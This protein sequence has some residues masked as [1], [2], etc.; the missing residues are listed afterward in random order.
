MRMRVGCLLAILIFGSGISA[1]TE[2]PRQQCRAPLPA[3][4]SAPNIFSAQQERDLG[5][6]VAESFEG[7][8]TIVDDEALKA[9]LQKI[10]DRLTAHLPPIDLKV[11]VDLVDSPEAN[12]FAL[13]GGRVYI[14]RKL[15]G[16]TRREDELAAVIGHELG[17][18][19]TRQQSVATTR[20]LREVLGVTSLSD[21]QDVFAKYN[22]LME[23]ANRKPGL[24]RGEN[25]ETAD[26]LEAD[27][28]GLFMMAAAGYDPRAH[29][30]LYARFTG[31]E[32]NTGGFFSRLFGTISP[33]ARRLGEMVKGA[34][35]L[36]AGCT[37]P[38]AP[39]PE[40]YR[41]WQVALAAADVRNRSELL[42]GLVRQIPLAPF[43]DRVRHVRFSPD[44]KSVLVQDDSTVFVLDRQPFA[45]RF[46]IPARRAF[47]AE[48][49]PD[50]STV[51]F[52]TPDLRV[53]RWSVTGKTL[54]DVYDVHWPE[55]CLRSAVSPDGRT[56]AC[57]DL[58]GTLTVIDAVSGKPVFQQKS[59]YKASELEMALVA[60]SGLYN[61]QTSWGIALTFSPSG[62][63][64]AAGYT[65]YFGSGALVYD[66]AA[67]A[68]LP[69]KDNAKRLI[70]G[71]FAFAGPDRIVGMNQADFSKSGLVKLPEGT[72]SEQVPLPAAAIFRT[73]QSRYLLMKPFPG[74]P[75]G[76]FD[77]QAKKAAIGFDALAVDAFD[78]EYVTDSGAGDVG[79]F[80]IEGRKPIARVSLPASPLVSLRTAT[81]SPDF[82][83]LAIS[84]D[85]RGAVWNTTRP[86]GMAYMRDFDG[87]VIDDKG[88]LFADF[89]RSGAEPR[90]IMQFDAANRRVVGGYRLGAED[91]KQAGPWLVLRRLISGSR[92]N[93]LGYEFQ[94][95]DVRQAAPG[96]TRKFDQNPPDGYWLDP[97]G[98]ALALA[99][100]AESPGGRIIVARDERLKKTVDRGDVKGD[101]V[102]EVVDAAGGTTRSRVLV[103]TG[104]GSFRIDGVLV[105]GDRM[106]VTD[107]L[108]RVLLY[109]LAT[110]E[111]TGQI[112]GDSPTLSADGRRLAVKTGE[113]RLAVHDVATLRRLSVLKF[114]S[115]VIFGAF[116]PDGANLFA[117][118]AEQTAHVIQIAK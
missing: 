5:D 112:V 67:K 75:I 114:K 115:D 28:V 60:M 117:L 79:L 4:S 57:V 72:V 59:F 91:A 77:V 88:M 16:L 94:F 89:P 12:A 118:T 106:F 63:Y 40:S 116:S 53:E 46:S 27:R 30:E 73:A 87:S 101:V 24:F 15:V 20:Q 13:P 34:T 35:A 82:Q 43:R 54:S 44:G 26:Q 97:E 84:G 110:G 90:T 109:S 69:L 95:R 107:S 52:H 38:S 78:E 71:T 3:P 32:G 51:V 68:V 98:D 93:P 10:V 50:S 36:P 113:G 104:K 83:W 7:Y 65:A 17:H 80:S 56:V 99:W 105:R 74:S 92:L 6:A 66:V 81:V 18:L 41:A 25:R 45:L 48:F 62:Q 31:S 23:N 9:P 22:Q 111:V 11:R 58:T 86:Q 21:R 8:L 19:V 64:L 39:V 42:P 47:L 76:F 29:A 85:T 1:R 61:T 33:D 2:T 14:T 100:W 102:I 37:P 96:W 108:G 55:T 70:S 103:E 49:S